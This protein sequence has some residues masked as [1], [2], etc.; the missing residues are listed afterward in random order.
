MKGKQMLRDKKNKKFNR[1]DGI[2]KLSKKK[3]KRSKQQ[4][5][6]LLIRSKTL[7]P[8]ESLRRKMKSRML[9]VNSSRN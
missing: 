1:P 5:V 6:L 9:L 4:L 8:T 7:S 2:V 3:L